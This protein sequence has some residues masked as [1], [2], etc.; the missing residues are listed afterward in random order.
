MPPSAGNSHGV[1]ARSK[2]DR[3]KVV[4]HFPRLV[5]GRCSP[6][7]AGRMKSFPFVASVGGGGE[8]EKY[9]WRL[10]LLDLFTQVD[11]ITHMP[12]APDTLTI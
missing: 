1:S 7:H 11:E 10:I 6:N 3:R 9:I 8:M 5:S 2:V 12:T 4:T